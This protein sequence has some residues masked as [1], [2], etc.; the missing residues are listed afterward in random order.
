M[1]ERNPVDSETDKL[2]IEGETENSLE[3][4][5]NNGCVVYNIEKVTKPPKN[6]AILA[7]KNCL[8]PI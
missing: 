3:K 1:M 2:V 8:L 5:G 4:I 7:L 6:N